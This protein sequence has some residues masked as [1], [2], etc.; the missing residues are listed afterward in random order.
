MARVVV[1]G[2]AGFV[3]ERLMSKLASLGIEAIGIDC[4]WTTGVSNV[5]DVTDP[6]LE[7]VLR[8]EDVLIH[9]GAISTDPLCSENPTQAIRTN[10][11]GTQ[12]VL[13][14]GIRAGISHLIFASTEWVYGSGPALTV[15]RETDP[16]IP[17]ELGSLYAQTKASG[18][19]LV[20]LHKNILSSAIL[21]FGIVYGPRN[22]GWSA[23]E[24][25]L[26]TVRI[27]D[28]VEVGSLETARRFIYVDDIVDGLI[29]S[30]SMRPS[31][32]FNMG[33]DKLVTLRDI[34]QTSASLLNREPQIRETSPDTP[35][36]RDINTEKISGALQW[37]PQTQLKDGLKSVIDYF[38]VEQIPGWR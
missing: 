30:V 15:L 16:I 1:T 22:S 3:G 21:R 8:S 25:L 7:G 20:N 12:N 28:T 19:A 13:E 36:I 32:I 10:V 29:E 14:C 5:L 2:A 26:N 9:L 4:K 33:G 11:E 38:E 17:L 27:Q 18:E 23:V 31:G 24:G 6:G 34:I 35:S 37:R